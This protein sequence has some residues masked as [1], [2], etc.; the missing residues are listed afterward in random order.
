MSNVR[1]E[2]DTMGEI[3]VPAD[4]YWGAQTERSL[5]HFAIA[6][7]TMPPAVVRAFGILK[8]ASARVNHALG[9]LSA[10]KAE[11]IERAA[12]E[13]ADGT[14]MAEFPLRIW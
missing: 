14:L 12:R 1:I 9:K 8:L 4:R 6:R 7:D 2:S 13:V 10:E 3:E 5:H 11:L